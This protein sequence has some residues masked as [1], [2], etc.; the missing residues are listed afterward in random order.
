M[1]DFLV[2]VGNGLGADAWFERGLRAAANAGSGAPTFDVRGP[3]VRAA[4]WARRNRSGGGTA[5]DRERWLI[6]S[7]TWFSDDGTSSG[8]EAQLLRASKERD[9]ASIGNGL[10]GF[11]ALAHGDRTT[12]TIVTDPMGCRHVYARAENGIAAAGTSAL[13]LAALDTTALDPVGCQE[14]LATG[15]MYEDRTPYAAVRALPPAAVIALDG[16]TWQ[17]RARTWSIRSLDP[18]TL[19]ANEAVEAF[20]SAMTAVCRRVARALPRPVA[21]LGAGWDSRILCAFLRKADVGFETTVTGRPD[22]VDVVLSS[23]IARRVGL[24]HHVI[25]AGAPPDFDEIVGSITLTDGL[26][27]ALGFARVHRAHAELSRSFGASLDGSFGEVARGCGWELLGSRPADLASLDAEPIARRHYAAD[28]TPL[29]LWSPT[30]RLDPLPHF[31]A[32]VRRLDAE[33]ECGPRSFRLDRLHLRMQMRCRHG[34]IAGSTDRHWPCLSPLS[35]RSAL[36]PLLRTR[37]SARRNNR[38][39]RAVLARF[40]PDLARLPLATGGTAMPRTPWNAWRFAPEALRFAK[41][42]LGRPARARTIEESAAERLS[43]W[44][45]ERVHDLL[46]ARRMALGDHVDREALAALVK[47]TRAPSLEPESLFGNLLALELGLRRLKSM[48][49]A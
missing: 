15:V 47:A 27:D 44:S 11:F 49:G 37:A 1:T 41:Q 38:L 32:L 22:D 24:R 4:A 45:D 2:V 16:G 23:R 43:L 10:E 13:V 12:A 19:D 48:R 36:E 18:E 30:E 21:E 6:A 34:R 14:F 7:G 20:G 29:A 40:A 9:P 35:F 33:L 26:C 46:D 5:V 3:R 17:L 42:F 31:T 8:D 39:A 28:A 25:P